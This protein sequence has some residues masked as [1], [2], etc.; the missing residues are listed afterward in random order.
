MRKYHTAPVPVWQDAS[1]RRFS[2]VSA[3]QNDFPVKIFKNRLTSAP[4]TAT[5][6]N[7]QAES[8]GM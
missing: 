5:M 7:A 1:F 2:A 8:P 4:D 3:M 6:R